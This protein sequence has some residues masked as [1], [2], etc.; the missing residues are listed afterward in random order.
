MASCNSKRGAFILAALAVVMAFCLAPRGSGQQQGDEQR[1]FLEVRRRQLELQAARK[2]AE[3]TEKLS[4][5]GLVPQTEVDRERNNVA[6]AQLNYQQAVLALLDLQ[7][8]I[9]VRSAVK[10]QSADG[11][12]FVDL[13]IVNLTPTFDDS[14]FKLLNNF[15]G[16]DPIPEQLRTRTVNDIF[17]SLRDAG[18]PAAAGAGIA[19]ATSTTISVPYEVHVA[20]M[21]YGETRALKY[22]LL[23][24]VDSVI[25]ALT[26][27]NQTTEIPVQLQHS[28]NGSDVQISSSQLSQE[29]DLGSQATYNLTFE[30]PSVDVRSFQLKVINLPRQITYSFIDPQS[31]ARLSQIN[32]SPGV[33]QQTLGLRL[34]LP[35]RAD[36][37]VPVDVPLEFWAL[38]LDEAAAA[39]IEQ[40]R[41]YTSAEL[42]VAGSGKIRLVIIP[43]G[44]GK[45]ETSAISLFSEIEIGQTVE[46]K[47]TVRNTGTRRLDNVRLSAE[48]PPNWRVRV[49]PDLIAA[50]GIGSE[51]EVALKI[52]T[53]PDAGVGDYEVRIRTESFADNRRVQSEDKIYRISVKARTN[54]L[55]V[56]A[57]IGVVLI[58]AGGV[59]FAGVKMTRR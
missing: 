16:A 39:R 1:R 7:P 24:D 35:E 22:Q 58:L 52:V 53:P 42:G 43:R 6:T 56:S 34:F 54:L 18:G 41:A 40:G 51:D 55:R 45:I 13:E 26:Y 19:R 3:R 8:R 38:A 36:N 20:Q 37:Q 11:R 32:F 30:R 10:T 33:T 23:R 47:I 9:S 31:Q 4:A 17:I 15:E 44:V 29:S 5:Q 28:A 50:L 25:V 49:E 27:R 57:L 59:V 46:T 2:Q 12:K 14:Q 48:C 21:K